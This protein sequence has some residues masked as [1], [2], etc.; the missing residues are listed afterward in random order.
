MNNRFM[1]MQMAVW[2]IWRIKRTVFMPVVFI[3]DMTVRV[4]EGFVNMQ[5]GV[6]L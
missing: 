1:L 2:F 4:N 5:V 3:V 6:S